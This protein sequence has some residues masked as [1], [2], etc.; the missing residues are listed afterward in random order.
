MKPITKPRSWI[1]TSLLSAV[2]VAYVVFVFLPGQRAIGGMRK[3]LH[4]KQQYVVQADRLTFAIQ[5]A[6]DDLQ[7]A[8]DYAEEWRTAAPSEA[9]LAATFGRI[10]ERAQQAGLNVHRFDP[11][12]VVKFDS[13][14]QAPI[15]LVAEG[16]FQQ[17]F[18]FVRLVEAMPGTVWVQ[19]LRLES[20]A[21]A[22]GRL[23]CEL[24][25]TVFADNRDFSE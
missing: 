16:D 7:A 2:A 8:H 3:Q 17:I 10:T 11:R 15:S 20:D 12:P 6:T 1:V 9:K 24:T 25:L 14:W 4:E 13:I 5:K 23:R 18:E 22:D 19:D 21:K